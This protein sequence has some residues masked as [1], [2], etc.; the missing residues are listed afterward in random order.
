MSRED[1]IKWLRENLIST[2]HELDLLCQD[3]Y[4]TREDWVAA[5]GSLPGSLPSYI[6]TMKAQV[7]VLTREL[8][9]LESGS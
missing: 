7:V 5:Y 3:G 9:R 6:A 1:R 2:C 4:G 8:M